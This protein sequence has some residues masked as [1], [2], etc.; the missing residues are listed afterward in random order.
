MQK[1]LYW[2]DPDSV[3]II[4]G[5]VIHFMDCIGKTP[6]EIGL[7]K[8]DYPEPEPTFTLSPTPGSKPS[9]TPKAEKTPGFEIL[10]TLA[11]LGGALYALNKKRD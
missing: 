6:A 2:E 1:L 10:A 9:S 8:Y 7:D 4:P 3:E 11:G 5:K